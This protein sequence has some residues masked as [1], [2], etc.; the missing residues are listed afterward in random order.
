M[1]HCMP[2]VVMPACSAQFVV[3]EAADQHGVLPEM[4]EVVGHVERRA[5]QHRPAWKH[6][7]EHLAEQHDRV[8]P[9]LAGD[10]ALREEAFEMRV[11]YHRGGLRCP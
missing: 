1:S 2:A 5:A 4:P 7:R 9:Y 8:S 11:L 6:V 10:G 3:A